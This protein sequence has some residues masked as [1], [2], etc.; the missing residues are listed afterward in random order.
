MNIIIDRPKLVRVVKLYLTK[1]FGNLTPK[2]SSE[3]PNSLFYA[4]SENHIFM[5]YDKKNERVRVSHKDI[6][7]KLERYFYLNYDDIQLIIKDWLEE[8]YK[9]KGVTPTSFG[10]WLTKWLE[11]AYKL[12]GV[13][14]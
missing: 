3:Y 12:K 5:E 1:S 8:A 9:L 7:S 6:W 13:T 14:P 11:E 10:I 2:I 4:D